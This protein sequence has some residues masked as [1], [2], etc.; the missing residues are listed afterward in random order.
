MTQYTMQLSEPDPNHQGFIRRYYAIIDVFMSG[1]DWHWIQTDSN[2]KFFGAMS[3]SHDTSE[4]ALCDALR[5][6]GGDCWT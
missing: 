1:S 3:G 4:E 2:G 6:L 5:K